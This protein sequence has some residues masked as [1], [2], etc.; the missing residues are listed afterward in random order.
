M[1]KENGEKMHVHVILDRRLNAFIE[2]QA[3]KMGLNRSAYIRMLLARESAK[4]EREEREG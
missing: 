3:A 2:A 1:L 4:E